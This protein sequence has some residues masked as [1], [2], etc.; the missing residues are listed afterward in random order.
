[1]NSITLTQA[2]SIY[3]KDV[4]RLELAR[5]YL[6]AELPTIIATH[7][8]TVTEAIN[9]SLE[10]LNEERMWRLLEALS[11]TFRMNDVFS[12]ITNQALDW[13]ELELP[14][15]AITLGGTK[16]STNKLVYSPTVKRNPILFAR[17]L[18]RYFKAHPDIGDDPEDLNDFRPKDREVVH[19]I[20]MTRERAG[21]IVMLDGTHRLIAQAM[22]GADSIHTYSA[23]PNAKRPLSMVGDS[24][25]L[26]LRKMYE[27]YQNLEQREAIKDVTTMLARSSSDGRHA[28][29]AY[30][31]EY[32]RTP[33]LKEAG[34][35]ILEKASPKHKKK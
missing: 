30:W 11:Y 26:T 1:M 27:R 35:D 3:K 19:N 22:L 21:K 29:K 15:G 28:I 7:S 34:E 8:Q 10:R 25:F 9:D 12:C 32:P 31:I 18:N 23:T 14:L 4:D 20:V 13:Y 5:N 24:S 6:R 2:T 33:L 17:Y 16:P